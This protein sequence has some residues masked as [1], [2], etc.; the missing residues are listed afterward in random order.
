MALQHPP[1]E[2]KEFELEVFSILELCNEIGIDEIDP[3]IGVNEGSPVHL[4]QYWNHWNSITVLSTQHPAM[5]L[6]CAPID[7]PR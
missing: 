6:K 2:I 7:I 5:C 4:L 3:N 1:N